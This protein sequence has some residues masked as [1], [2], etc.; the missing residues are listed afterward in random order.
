M[1]LSP[2]RDITPDDVAAAQ[3]PESILEEEIEDT[4]L[5]DETAAMNKQELS[6]L[7]TIRRGIA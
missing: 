7:S 3:L 1:E 4:T 2:L 5:L 6:F